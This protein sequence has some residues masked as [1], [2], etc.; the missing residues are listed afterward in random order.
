MSRDAGRARLGTLEPARGAPREEARGAH[1]ALAGN[2]NTG[3]TTLF[4]RLTGARHKVGNYAG[5]T[6]DRHEGWLAL[7]G[8]PAARLVDVPG[9]HSLSARSAEEQLALR[10][11][12]GLEPFDMPDLVVVVVDA[13]QLA[14]NLYLVLQLLELGAPVVV[15]LNMIDMLEPRGQSIDAGALE[16]SLGVPVVPVSARKGRGLDELCE[17]IATALAAPEDASPGWRWSPGEAVA[18][19]LGAVGEHVPAAW[20]VQEADRRRAFAAWALLSLDE[21]DELDE[22]PDALR[23]CVGQRR[24]AAASAGRDLDQELVGERYTWIDAA[25]AGAL[26]ETA[27]GRRSISERVDA[28]L[29]N[30]LLGFTLFLLVMGALFQS[31]FSWA[32]PAIGAV[33]QVFAWLGASAHQALPAGFFKDLVTEGLIAGVG[34]VVVFLPQILLLFF[35][36]GLL[37]DTGYMARVAFLMDRLMRALSLNGRAF[38]PMLSGFACAIPAVMAT[39]TMERK[40]DRLL[41]MMAVPLMTCSA[42]L[43]VYTLI[44]AALFPPRE[45]WGFLPVQS[46]LMVAMYV[47]STIVAL[48]ALAILSRTVLRGPEVPIVLELPPYRLPHLPTVIRS[49]GQKAGAFLREAGT[50]ILA[51]TIGLWLLLAFPSAPTLEVDYEAERARV[52]STT[53]PGQ[54]REDTLA[55]LANAEASDR[56]AESYAGRLGRA[57]EP[58]IAPLGFDWKIGIGLIGSFAAREVFISTMGLVYGVGDEVD[59]GSSSLRE[60][61]RSE[62]RRDGSP[63]YTPLVGL[64][65]MVFFALACQCFSTLAVVKRETRGYRWP[66]FLM[67]YMTVLAWVASFIV[68]QGGKLLGLG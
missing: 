10:V 27:P 11:L 28:V 39:R 52:E 16:S 37:E 5:V 26:S 17:A 61:L 6:V 23:T 55:Q 57:I 33:E 43:P 56:L 36:L 3:K 22:A 54:N 32:N 7:P 53:S 35:L 8:R 68:Y 44:I 24:A 13:T 2:P 1:V 49:M 48:V 51:C 67:V 63:P 31:L 30:P 65:L 64:S 58:A 14:R 40:R 66:A 62:R 9:C 46:L 15:A 38:V 59:E 50:V 21:E 34:S 20:H 12:T 60:R 47:F 29:L 19:E 4:N 42:R 18:A 41:T 25:V 45:V